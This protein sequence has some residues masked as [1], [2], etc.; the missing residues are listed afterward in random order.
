[1]LTKLINILRKNPP[2]QGRLG[3][4]GH[5]N[6]LTAFKRKSNEDGDLLVGENLGEAKHVREVG[7]GIAAAELDGQLVRPCRT[8]FV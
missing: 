4:V 1:M 6:A 5:S 8:S 3:T 2:R 7:L